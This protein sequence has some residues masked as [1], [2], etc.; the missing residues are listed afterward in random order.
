MRTLPDPIRYLVSY[1]IRYPIRVPIPDRIRDPIP[2]PIYLL[3]DLDA[4]VAAALS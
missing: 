1:L 4:F 3:V 2:N